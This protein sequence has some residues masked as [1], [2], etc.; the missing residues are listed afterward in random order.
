MKVILTIFLIGIITFSIVVGTF[1]MYVFTMVDGKMDENLNDLK[2]NFTT[3]I[4]INDENGNA[5]EYQRLHGMFNRIWVSYD[6]PLAEAKD[7]SYK[8]IPQNLVNAF[9]AI[10]DKRFFSHKGVD[11]KRTASA[12]AN[13]ILKFNSA[14]YGGST[15]T[16]QLVKNLTGDN[17]RKPSRKI[18]EIMRARYFETHYAKDTIVECYLNTIAMGHGTYG[19]QVASN[20]YFNKNVSDLTLAE[21]ATLAA[22]TKSPTYFAPDDYPEANRKRMKAVLAE[23]KNQQYITE[24]E[25]QA[26]LAEEVKIVADENVLKQNDMNS[27]FVD[28]LIDQVVNDLVKTYG[29]E[30]KHAENMFYTAGYKIYA[31]LIP[32]VQDKIDAAFADTHSFA[33]KGK[34]GQT[35][36][37]SMTVMD[38]NGHVVALVGG[39]GEKTS[40]RGFNRATSAIRQPGSTMKPLSAYAPAIETDLVTYSTLINDTATNYNGWKPVNWYNSYLGNVTVEYALE[41]SINTIPVYLVNKMTPQFSFDFLTQKLGIT[42]LNA[43]DVNLAPLG[44][45]GTN[46]GITTLESAAA[47]AVFGN[48]GLY[49]SPTLYTKVTDQNG[50]TVLSQNTEPVL[51]ISEDTACIMNHLLRNVVYGA[52]GTGKDAASFI[53]QMKFYAKT[54]TSNDQKDL[55]FVGG[56]PYYIS[57]CWCG[58]DTQQD[59]SQSSIALRLWGAAMSK[60]HAGLEPKE[61]ADSSYVVQRYYCTETGGLATDAC[62]SKTLGWYKKNVL[63]STCK[64]HSG[65]VIAA[66]TKEELKQMETAQN[67]KT[68]SSAPAQ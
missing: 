46:G 8:G 51:A 38:Y 26:A 52:K 34:D 58:Y 10:E 20:Y 60:V 33:L 35:L 48:G 24:E 9:V 36:Q 65:T 6:R 1:L 43:E 2:L 17:S 23:L 30:K 14:N 56:S 49:Y 66:P 5:I 3:T 12:F 28:A 54:G 42:T 32:S 13:L 47:F 55:W 22:I 15:L 39:I 7:E 16:Q 64:S 4:Y 67:E 21:C 62:P 59:I 63:P 40:V 37:G 50:E 57:S 27:Y 68:D 18:R 61:F 19:V 41:R 29:Y 25:Y 45:G 11:W 31:T 44:M 53:P